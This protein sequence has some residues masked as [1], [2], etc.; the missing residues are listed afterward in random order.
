MNPMMLTLAQA[1]MAL[2]CTVRGAGDIA[3]ARVST[4]S[5]DIR[6]GDLFV[7]LR[8]ERFDGH[9]FV[10]DV[11]ARGAAAAMVEADHPALAQ[12]PADTPLLEVIDTT[13]AL[14][15]LAARW[16]DRFDGL[17]VI[18]VTGSSGKTTL[19]Q[20]IHAV[21]QNAHGAD[22]VLATEGNLNNQIGMP[23]TLLRLNAGHR[24]AVIEM[25]MNHFGEIDYLTRLARPDVAVINN[26]GTAHIEFLGSRQGIAQ[27]KGEIFAGLADDGVAVINLDDDFAG[28]WQGL[29]PGRRIV[30]FGLSQGALHAE[31]VETD[32]L[33]SRFTL[34]APDG[35]A[36]VSLP[37]PGLHNVRNALAA[38]AVCHALGLPVA[39]IASGLAHYQGAKGRLQQ[40]RTAAGALL[41]DDS[42]NANP[43]SVR[44]AIDVLARLPG[45]RWLVLGDMGELDDLENRHR[46]IGRYAASQGLSGF[47]AVGTQMRH[48]VEAYGAGAR[49]FDSHAALAEALAPQLGAESAVLVKGSLF[50]GMARVVDA[51]IA[52]NGKE[53]A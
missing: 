45:Q 53:G 23:L 4:D 2:D 50:M 42:Y 10:A 32:T 6:P 7:A 34:C 41:I 3:F 8:G 15:R 14:G 16:R 26:A 49:W 52:S 11:L 51:L 29:N 33:S 36:S 5:R 31:S 25:G 39:A 20:M 18:G 38:G 13:A 27:A 30:G 28:Y 43:D 46:D 19:K 12:L 21:L 1:A 40:K 17:T 37:T 35:Q 9:D 48:A 44:A 24:Y 22:A 47:Y